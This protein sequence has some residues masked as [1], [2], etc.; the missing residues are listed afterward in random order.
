MGAGREG[1]FGFVEIVV[2]GCG[3][4]TDAYFEGNFLQGGGEGDGWSNVEGEK[5]ATPGERSAGV[6]GVCT[7]EAVLMMGQASFQRT[8]LSQRMRPWV[9]RR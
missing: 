2:V 6:V 4:E 7:G 9:P 1:C 3:V 8:G 5:A